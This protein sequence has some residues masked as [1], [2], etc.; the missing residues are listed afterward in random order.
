MAVVVAKVKREAMPEPIGRRDTSPCEC[1]VIN[2]KIALKSIWV[3]HGSLTDQLRKIAAI[4]S[5]VRSVMTALP[6][7]KSNPPI[8]GS[9]ASARGAECQCDGST[10][11]SRP[12]FCTLG[13]RRSSVDDFIECLASSTDSVILELLRGPTMSAAKVAARPSGRWRSG[14]ILFLPVDLAVVP[15]ALAGGFES[16]FIAIVVRICG[17]FGALSCRP[18]A[19]ESQERPPRTQVCICGRHAGGIVGCGRR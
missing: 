19:S 9:N 18:C 3:Y 4:P 16:S 14:D 12:P 13:R 7:W 10:L 8:A 5:K 17:G 2:L 15:F 6:F 11:V 1:L